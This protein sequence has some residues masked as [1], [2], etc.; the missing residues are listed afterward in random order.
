MPVP[1]ATQE[2]SK[3]EVKSVIAMMRI[4]EG[5]RGTKVGLLARCLEP[6]LYLNLN[7]RNSSSP[8]HCVQYMGRRMGEAR[9]LSTAKVW[10]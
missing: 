10:V 6:Y 9:K 5:D 8:F 3:E 7:L 1:T 2:T 4:K